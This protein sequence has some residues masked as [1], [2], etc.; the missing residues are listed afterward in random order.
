MAPTSP[1]PTAQ[2]AV[3]DGLG[4]DLG[5]A[6]TEYQA[7]L[8]G[9][10][11]AK[12]KNANAVKAW[13]KKWDKKLADYRAE[14]AAVN[15]YNS[16]P[17]AQGTPAH[18]EYYTTTDKYGNQ[19]TV[20]RTVA[21][22][23]GHTRAMPPYPSK[24]T[25]LRVDLA[26]KRKRLTKLDT[27]LET[28]ASTLDA[29]ALDAELQPVDTA[30]RSGVGALQDKVAEARKALENV[31]RR[32]KDMGDVIRGE[33]LASIDAQGVTAAVQAVRDELVSAAQAL[34]VDLAELT[35]ASAQP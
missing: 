32:D 1:A 21:G 31:V 16:S 12:A 25:K 9:I 6:A 29:A 35:W 30:L 15:A 4:A 17:A 2:V 14:V 19:R 20:S 18:T 13:K 8:A 23:S 5:A 27:E 11:H 33:K 10:N 34:G 22:T 26:A 24:P 3:A 7:V 28:L